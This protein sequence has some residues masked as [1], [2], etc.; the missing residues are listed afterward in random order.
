[1]PNKKKVAAKCE[2]VAVQ[3]DYAERVG[4]LHW[5]ARQHAE[6]AVYCA[7][8]AGAVMLAKKKTLTH[9]HFLPWLATVKLQDGKE[10][11]QRTA[12]N[13]MA[14]AT[15]IA[16]RFRA[17]PAPQRTKLLSA[18]LNNDGANQPNYPPE[19]N[20]QPGFKFGDQADPALPV[21]EIL[22]SLKP[23]NVEDYRMAIVRELM[24]TITNGENLK[25]LY[26]DWGIMK[27]PAQIGGYHPTSK[28][29]RTLEQQRE[30]VIER[31]R[32][33]W[34]DVIRVVRYQGLEDMDWGLLDTMEIEGMI[35]DFDELSTKMKTALRARRTH[36]GRKQDQAEILKKKGLENAG[37]V[38]RRGSD[39][40]TS[41][42]LGIPNP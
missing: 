9:G 34:K 19:G 12:Y 4:N 24:R 2:S 10:I 40:G 29:P 37:A 27:A 22:A 15:G 7:A 33:N 38:P 14:L 17:M 13:Y 31:T 30:F 42:L 20:L 41:P 8:A 32:E 36:G 18:N 11:G 16:E 39:V 28:P 35:A 26:F 25:Q 23:G 1:M 21:L 6:L 5:M 3:D